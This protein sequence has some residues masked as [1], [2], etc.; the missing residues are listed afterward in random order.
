[1]LAILYGD[2]YGKVPV[3]VSYVLGEALSADLSINICQEPQSYRAS[4]AYPFIGSW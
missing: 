2:T 1:M 3:S 4:I